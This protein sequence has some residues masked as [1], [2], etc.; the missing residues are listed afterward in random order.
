M[1]LLEIIGVGYTQTP[2][3]HPTLV[4]ERQTPTDGVSGK[5]LLQQL[6]GWLLSLPQTSRHH[7]WTEVTH[8]NDLAVL[9]QGKIRTNN[10][11]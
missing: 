4:S 7:I 9:S 3:A 6:A 5:I 11:F 10:T 2:A 8:F 1:Q